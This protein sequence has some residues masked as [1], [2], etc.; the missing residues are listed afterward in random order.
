[1]KR[2][3]T[4]QFKEGHSFPPGPGRP[5]GLNVEI[6]K[7][8]STGTQELAKVIIERALAGDMAAAALILEAGKP[9]QKFEV[10][11]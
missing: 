5:R 9:Q 6:R 2:T 8:A 1:M 4:G 7:Q 10:I 11:R 3:R